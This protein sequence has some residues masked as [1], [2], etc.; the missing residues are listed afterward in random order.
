[1][2]SFTLREC[3]KFNARSERDCIWDGR[4]EASFPAFFCRVSNHLMQSGSGL[5]PAFKRVLEKR[6]T[7]CNRMDVLLLSSEARP[8]K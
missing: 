7:T 4:P 5:Y 3:S 8:Q 2:L 6:L 1:L